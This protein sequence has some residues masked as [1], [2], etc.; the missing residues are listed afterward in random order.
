MTWWRGGSH[1]S[2]FVMKLGVE[3]ISEALGLVED[4]D[5]ASATR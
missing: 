2:T 5:S 3:A 1:G 4:D